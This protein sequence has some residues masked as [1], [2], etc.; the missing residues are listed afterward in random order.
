MSNNNTVSNV[1][2]ERNSNS[3]EALKSSHRPDLVSGNIEAVFTEAEVSVKN[4]KSLV[5]RHTDSN[6]WDMIEA[7]FDNLSNSPIKELILL[8]NF[9]CDESSSRINKIAHLAST[10]NP[11][12]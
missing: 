2:R 4:N 12:R 9:N 10:F 8:R 3:F 6:Y 11:H 1:Q 7:S 5:A